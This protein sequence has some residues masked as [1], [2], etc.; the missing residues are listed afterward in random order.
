LA[1]QKENVLDFSTILQWKYDGAIKI[2]RCKPKWVMLSLQPPK[3][4]GQCNKFM[5]IEVDGVLWL[6][7]FVNV[8]LVA[9]YE[10]CDVYDLQHM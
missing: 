5:A 9:S 7:I 1:Y 6:S 10:H 4:K 3:A 8:C 2:L